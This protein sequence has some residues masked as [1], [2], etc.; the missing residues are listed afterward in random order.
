[1]FIY[2]CPLK[3]ERRLSIA[4]LSNFRPCRLLSPGRVPGFFKL[5]FLSSQLSAETVAQLVIESKS[6]KK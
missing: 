4:L 2:Q 5:T 3:L 6:A 1:V